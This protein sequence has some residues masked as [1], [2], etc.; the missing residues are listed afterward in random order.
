[1]ALVLALWLIVLLSIMAA[2]H[3]RN[4]HNDTQ[5]ASRQLQSAKARGLA[6]AGINHMILEMIAANSRRKIPLDGS[7][8]TRRI[9]DDLVTI[10][11]RDTRGLVDINRADPGLLDAALIAAGADET[12]RPHLVDS[13]QDWRDKDDLRRLN[14]VEDNDYVSAGMPWR[15]RDSAFVALEE[16][17][18]LPGMSQDV[19]QRLAPLVT[20]YGGGGKTNFDLAPPALVAAVRGD[21]LPVANGVNTQQTAANRQIVSNGTFHIYASAAGSGVVASIEAVVSVSRSSKRPFTI[22]EWREPSR[23]YLPPVPG[24]EE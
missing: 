7:V 15:S 9:G 4:A 14:G 17:K 20:I 2:G 11:V 3:S 18:Y 19:F 23:Q 24:D 13:I 5:I 21:P 1:M 16:L 10:A 12:Q 8:I 22:L 6:E